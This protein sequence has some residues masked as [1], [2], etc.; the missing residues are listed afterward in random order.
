MP[1]ARARVARVVGAWI[2]VIAAQQGAGARAGRAGVAGGTRI[3]VVA[4]GGVGSVHA[5]RLG[6]AGVV[7]AE[8]AVVAAERRTAH[9]RTAGG[10]VVRGAGVGVVA[11]GRVGGVPAAGRRAG[12]VGGAEG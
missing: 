12:G 9:P 11:G 6:P 3:A 5:P 2:A 1:A 4:G 10:G 7:G 8:V